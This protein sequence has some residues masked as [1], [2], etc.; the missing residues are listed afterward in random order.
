VK[1][2]DKVRIKLDSFPF[3]KFGT[4]QGV[5]TVVSE[6]AFARDPAAI[7]STRQLSGNY[8]LARVKLES[9]RLER[10]SED[11][12]LRPGFT[13]AGEIKIGE[14][15]VMSYFVYPLIGTLDASL[16]ERR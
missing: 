4:L 14:R 5:I 16:R 8:Y 13:L 3:Q 9:T 10:Q 11:V 12:A 1:V 7:Q 2:G 15:S 6:D